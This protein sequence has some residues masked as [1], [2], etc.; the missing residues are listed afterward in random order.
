MILV[1]IGQ[2]CRLLPVCKD[3]RHRSRCVS[4]AQP[5]HRVI[6][7]YYQWPHLYSELRNS[8]TCGGPS[9]GGA[10]V[11]NCAPTFPKCLKVTLI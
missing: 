9:E 10:E 1:L 6:D 3:I 11:N 4:R 7:R 5:F 8:M 2:G